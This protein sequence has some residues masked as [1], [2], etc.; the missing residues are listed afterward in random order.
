VTAVARAEHANRVLGS[1]SLAGFAGFARVVAFRTARGFMDAR[2]WDL[3]ASLAYASLISFVP[4]VACIT[5]LSS[6]LFGDPGTGVLRLIR[7]VVPGLTRELARDIQ[8][9]A[10]QARSVSGWASFFFLFTSLRM[11][12]LLE[13]AANALW[14]TT[15]KRRALKRLG[16]GIFFVVLGPV[17]AGLGTSLLLESGAKFSEFR[18][19]GLFIT[20]AILTLL[21]WAIPVAHVRWAP[22]AAAGVLVGSAIAFLKY[23]LTRGVAALSGISRV[24][25]SISAVVILVLALGIVWTLLLLGVSFAHALQ[26]RCE[27]LAHDE[28][29]RE[30]RRGGPLDEAVRLLTMLADAWH[31][32]HAVAL[33]QLS[34]AVRRPEP[35][36][37][38][39]LK[40]LA[41]AELV[42]VRRVESANAS[43][44]PFTPPAGRSVGSLLL[45]LTRSPEEISLYTVARALGES[46]PRAVPMGDDPTSVILRGIYRRADREVR[47]VLQGT[48]LRDVARPRRES[49]RVPS[50]PAR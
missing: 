35:E 45:E 21:Y 27:L 41:N 14:G 10:S 22:A 38:A 15:L 18:F 46:V 31:D 39:R 6:T 36:V 50:G 49:K 32:G 30:A 20:C 37:A 40:L 17:A 24:Y 11:Y 43:G 26:F 33:S 2:G 12:F 13:S 44:D 8:A 23:E 9:L 4:L 28:P 5:V 16:V 25:G 42:A 3:A 29:E 48:S 7:L 34:D 47:S 19:S 1:G